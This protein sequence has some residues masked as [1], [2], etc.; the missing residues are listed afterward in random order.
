MSAL[1]DRLQE[2]QS[3]LKLLTADLVHLRLLLGERSIAVEHTPEEDAFRRSYV[4]A[5]YA[6]VEA[7]V[8][9]QAR[10]LVALDEGD[11]IVLGPGVAAVLS[12]TS[13]EVRRNG[14]VSAR[15]LRLSL[16]NK[17]RAVYRAA[18]DSVDSGIEV[19]F[20]EEGWEAFRSALQLLHGLTH[21]KS[22]HDCHVEEEDLDVV[23]RAEG[24]YQKAH[25][26]LTET[27][28]LHRGR[29]HW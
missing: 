25:N 21:P 18:H 19:G 24:W 10:L 17:I 15:P 23:E 5:F 3:T 26:G 14:T 12:D 8:E 1:Y 2:L 6:L 16:E 29:A 9:Q 22:P 4:R 28:R 27:L 7:L 20:G 13:Y 11:F